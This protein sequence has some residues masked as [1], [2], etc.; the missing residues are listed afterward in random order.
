M[1][2]RSK[3]IP[4]ALIIHY[5]ISPHPKTVSSKFFSL[6]LL[7]F[8]AHPCYLNSTSV[9]N[10]DYPL[11]RAFV[12]LTLIVY[13]FAFISFFLLYFFL[14]SIPLY[15]LFLNLN[16]IQ[17]CVSSK[18]KYCLRNYFYLY[19]ALKKY[20]F[21]TIYTFL[22]LSPYKYFAHCLLMFS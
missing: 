1:L 3:E 4:R 15:F 20:I 18:Y 5:L 7:N 21:H 17:T 16:L 2:A 22:S 6:F 12:F 14:F 10:Y 13:I 19:V 9:G 8:I 11:F